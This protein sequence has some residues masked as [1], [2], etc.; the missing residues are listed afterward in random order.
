MVVVAM[1]A[2]GSSFVRCMM[3]VGLA[4]ERVSLETELS[5][6]DGCETKPNGSDRRRL[7]GNEVAS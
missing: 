4:G 2:R 3:L 1:A 7:I 5:E 6:R